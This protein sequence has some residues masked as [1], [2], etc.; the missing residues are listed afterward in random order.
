MGS[1]KR[2]SSLREV[3]CTLRYLQRL[4]SVGVG[5]GW[6]RVTLL[7]FGITWE[8]QLPLQLTFSNGWFVLDSFFWTLSCCFYAWPPSD[9]TKIIIIFLLKQQDRNISFKIQHPWSSAI[10][11]WGWIASSCSVDSLRCMYAIDMILQITIQKSVLY[12][13]M[14]FVFWNI[15]LKLLRPGARTFTSGMTMLSLENNAKIRTL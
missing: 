9:L 2:S 10:F 14:I 8:D 3:H 12:R 7:C 11:V 6:P 15:E 1:H 4:C 5:C 13:C